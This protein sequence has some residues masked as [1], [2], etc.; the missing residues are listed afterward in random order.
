MVAEELAEE[1]APA[2]W[3]FLAKLGDEETALDAGEEPGSR[4]SLVEQ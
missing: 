1:L 3:L 2:G 4:L